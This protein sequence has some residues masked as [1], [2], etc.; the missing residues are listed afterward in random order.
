MKK[1][2]GII[3]AIVVILAISLISL[4]GL[5]VLYWFVLRKKVFKK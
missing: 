4:S 3:I 2:L 1:T 5:F